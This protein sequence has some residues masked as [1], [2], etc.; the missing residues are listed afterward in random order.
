[1]KKWEWECKLTD[2]S[3]REWEYE[4]HSRSPVPR[5]VFQK[6][7]KVKPVLVIIRYCM[8]A[9]WRSGSCVVHV[10][11]VSQRPAGLVLDGCPFS[12]I[13]SWY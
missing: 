9:V 1:V 2:G 8:V 13:P 6:H 12:G 7:I 3:E 11:K 4:L 5:T 10:N